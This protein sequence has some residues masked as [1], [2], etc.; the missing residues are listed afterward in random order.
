MSRAI[1]EIVV[2]SD[3]CM[4]SC[5]MMMKDPL[6]EPAFVGSRVRKFK[7]VCC[8]HPMK[9]SR[10]NASFL[11]DTSVDA[12]SVGEVIE[13][14]MRAMNESCNLMEE[15]LGNLDDTGSLETLRS[16][17]QSWSKSSEII[18]RC[19]S[20]VLHV[21]SLSLR[22]FLIGN[23]DDCLPAMGESP[24]H[25]LDSGKSHG[26]LEMLGRFTETIHVLLSDVIAFYK[27]EMPDW[28]AEGGA[29]GGLILR[30]DAILSRSA[31]LASDITATRK[32]GHVM[33]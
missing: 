8:V 24:T 33:C 16:L 32:V 26:G 10:D 2:D 21:H 19:C 29:S 4:K 30:L 17:A 9:V 12:K 18:I 6:T 7:Q 14:W 15:L 1:A 23:H 25:P 27:R 31:I 3:S 5:K 11:Q 20:T 13:V 22:R 28:H